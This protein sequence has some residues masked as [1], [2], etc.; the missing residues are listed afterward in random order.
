MSHCAGGSDIRWS[1]LSYAY[2]RGQHGR[3]I[4]SRCSHNI[5]FCK[6]INPISIIVSID[7]DELFY[8]NVFIPYCLNC[9][10]LFLIKCNIELIALCVVV[11]RFFDGELID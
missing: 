3:R 6:L 7:E 8:F 9:L 4:R 10:F 1:H 11:K 5:S 2:R